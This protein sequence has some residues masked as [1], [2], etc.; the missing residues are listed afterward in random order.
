MNGDINRVYAI[1]VRE[2]IHY[3]RHLKERYPYLFSFAVRTN[4]FNQTAS[5]IVM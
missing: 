3:L 5:V 2:W 4:P 1:L